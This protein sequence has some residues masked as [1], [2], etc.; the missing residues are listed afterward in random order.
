MKQADM[1]VLGLAGAAVF[2]IFQAQRKGAGF[3][4]SGDLVGNMGKKAQSFVDEIFDAAG[5][6]FDNGWRYF[7]NGTAISPE[8]DY[9][10]NGQ[11]VYQSAPKLAG[12]SGTW[13]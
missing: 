5:K 2:L 7:E 3:A 6:A 12:A 11:M 13:A 4:T 1:I 10:L 8:G 9:Y